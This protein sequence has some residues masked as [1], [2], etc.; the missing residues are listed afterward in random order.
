MT[1]ATAT[2]N[3]TADQLTAAQKEIREWFPGKDNAALRK[4]LREQL[5]RQVDEMHG[6]RIDP[7]C[8]VRAKLGY[9]ILFLNGSGDERTQNFNADINKALGLA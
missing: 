7:F 1:T 3:I 5:Q 9:G 4:T 8:P 2:I 6:E